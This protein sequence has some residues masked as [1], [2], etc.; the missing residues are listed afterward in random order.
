MYLNRYIPILLILVL[1]L[2]YACKD[3]ATNTGTDPDTG[4][5]NNPPENNTGKDSLDPGIRDDYSDILH[6]SNFGK[7]GSYNVHDPTLIKSGDFYYMYSTDVYYGGAGVDSDDPRLDPKIPIRRSKD[8][9]H[10]NPIG[11]VYGEMPSEIVSWMRENVQ[12]DYQPEAVWAPYIME[13]DGQ[14]RLYFSVPANDRQ[15][16][17]LGLA[18]S[19]NP[20]G[21]WTNKGLVLPTY[22]GSPYNGIDPA[23]VVDRDNG[24]YWLIFGSWWNG[25]HTVEL[26]PDTGFRKDPEDTGTIIASRKADS[27]S[28]IGLE[29]AEVIYN[30]EFNK[31]YLFVSYGPLMDK[32]NVRVGRADQPQGPYYDFFGNDMS[33]KTDNYPKLTAQYKFNNHSGWQ[34]VGHTGLLRDGDD[35]YLASQGRLGRD[36]NLMDLHLRKMVWTD[37]GW[38]VLSP[39]RY[40]AIPQEEI[41]ADSLV[42][43]WEHITLD[44]TDIKNESETLTFQAD[45]SIKEYEQ[46]SWSL[47]GDMLVL[48]LNASTNFRAHVMRGWDWENDRVCL[49]FSGLNSDGISEWGKRVDE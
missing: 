10:W 25:I 44:K 4:G 1:A 26:D 11:H 27:N 9:V 45:G 33:D 47:D 30:P 20:E 15:G 5:E 39:E 49:L 42:G 12:S 46:G 19:S 31:Y 23:V 48:Q 36:P 28:N 16:V 7:W 35:Y 22:D 21:P 13:V 8:L 14:Y 34:G 32:Y 17:Y 6:I 24:R 18:V 37:D 38:P 40:A 29:G 3:S 43:K 41:T 2:V